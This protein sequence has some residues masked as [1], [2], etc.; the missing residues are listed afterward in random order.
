MWDAHTTKIVLYVATQSCIA[1]QKIG[2][3]LSIS[4]VMNYMSA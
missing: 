4:K 2:V 3:W 1:I